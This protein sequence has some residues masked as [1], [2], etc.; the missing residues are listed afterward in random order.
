[1]EAR[2]VEPLSE[3]NLPWFSPGADGHFHSLALPSAV[4]LQGLVAS[5]YMLRAKLTAVTFTT[6]SRP[7]PDPW[8]YRAGRQ[9]LFRPRT[10]KR[11]C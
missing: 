7:H 3:N 5:F 8:S 6:E 2:G 1:M 9:P 10:R 4:R 11:N